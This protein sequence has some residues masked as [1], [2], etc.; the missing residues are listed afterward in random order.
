M[1]LI[2]KKIKNSIEKKVWPEFF[3]KI[4][5]GRKKYELRLADFE[6]KEGDML[7]LK[8]WDPQTKEYI[9]RTL[10]KVVTF[11]L[12]TNDQKFWPKE[13]VKKYGFQIIAFD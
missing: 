5:D 7:F 1:R 12:K 3:Q 2:E 10:E 9:G 13:D 8:E 11:V 6:C 4:M